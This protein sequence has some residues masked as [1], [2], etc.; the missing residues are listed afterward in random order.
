MSRY[1]FFSVQTPSR[2]RSLALC[3]QSPSPL[4]PSRRKPLAIMATTFGL[5]LGA[6]LITTEREAHADPVA[7]FYAGKSITLVI[8][9]SPGGGYDAYGRLISRHMGAHIPGRPGF[10]VQNMPGAGGLRA[11]NF[12]ANV[13][14][15]D[16]LT[17]GG[18]QNGVPFEPL[19]RNAGA[20]FDPLDFNWLGSPNS[21]VGLLLVWHENPVQTLEQAMETELVMAAS[22]AAST[23]AFFARIL[24][25]VFN[26]RLRVIPGYPGQTEAFLAMERGEVDGYPST[27]W[28]SLKAQWP[29]WVEEN[30][31]RILLQYGRNP[32]PE[33]PNVPVARA[34]ASTEADR[35]L[36]DLAMAPLVLGRPY[37]AP[38]GVPEE[39]VAALRTAMAAT[40]KSPAFLE[41]AGRLRL[42]VDENPLSGEDIGE[43]L[44]Q[45]YNAP[46]DV[47][48]RL[49]AIYNV[50]R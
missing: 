44:K 28:S 49:I 6:A 10:I 9:S 36:L 33:L 7:E 34:L 11:G 45:T 13:A 42:E 5:M 16:G 17:I 19:F 41:E 29:Q 50:G 21:E 38:P 20:Q 48:D 2:S 37:M 31:V 35:T 47:I 15:K 25:D 8:S 27:F 3:D 1:R 23:P 14:S 4:P 24:N 18:V 40:F 39:R 43:I 32:H 30:R 26:T 22:G 12:I 46:T